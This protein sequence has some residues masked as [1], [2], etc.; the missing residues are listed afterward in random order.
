LSFY[1]Q[2]IEVN[3]GLGVD[4]L[5]LRRSQISSMQVLLA[6]I[7]RLAGARTEVKFMSRAF[8]L[9]ELGD[10]VLAKVAVYALEAYWGDQPIRKSRRVS[11]GPARVRA[12]RPN[13]GQL[14]QRRLF[15]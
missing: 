7:E 13:L 1:D 8:E 11:D 6:G 14:S 9:T 2:H 4:L 5:S 3:M 12:R 15:A 10:A